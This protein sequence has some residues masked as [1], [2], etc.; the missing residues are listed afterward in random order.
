[1][2]PPVTLVQSIFALVRQP[3]LPEACCCQVVRQRVA[4]EV[5][6][7]FPVGTVALVRVAVLIY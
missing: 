4:L 7:N 2:P 3:A 5:L 1:M 6:F